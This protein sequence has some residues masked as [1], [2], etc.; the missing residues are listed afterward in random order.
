MK[1][2]SVMSV[3]INLSHIFVGITV[4][5]WGSCSI[6]LINM[7]LAVKKNEMQMG[8]TSIVSALVL[9]FLLII[10]LAVLLKMAIRGSHEL[11]VL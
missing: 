11:V 3:Y 2:V 7:S 1:V 9:A 6:E 4:M 5:S 8:L 10:P